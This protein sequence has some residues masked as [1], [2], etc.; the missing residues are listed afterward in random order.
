MIIKLGKNCSVLGCCQNWR[1]LQ[2]LAVCV[3]VFHFG[4]FFPVCTI[5]S[6]PVG[7]IPCYQHFYFSCDFFTGRPYG[8]L[9]VYRKILW[10]LLNDVHDSREHTHTNTHRKR[11]RLLMSNYCHNYANQINTRNGRKHLKSWRDTDEFRTKQTLH[12][13]SMK[14]RDRLKDRRREW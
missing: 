2:M 3:C 9:F 12:K 4:Y 5:T 6:R 7:S 10:K 14:P 1:Q 13:A 11:D 8:S